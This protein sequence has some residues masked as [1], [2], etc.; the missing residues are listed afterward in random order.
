[1]TTHQESPQIDSHVVSAELVLVDIPVI[2]AESETSARRQ[3]KAGKQFPVCFGVSHLPPAATLEDLQTELETKIV[4]FRRVCVELGVKTFSVRGVSP[5]LIPFLESL[6]AEIEAR[7][8][9]HFVVNN[10][11][12][13]LDQ[14]V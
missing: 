7:Y 6:G 4:S 14:T 11:N 10:Y 8:T 9:A 2:S 1:M 12:I 5:E 13:A 3:I